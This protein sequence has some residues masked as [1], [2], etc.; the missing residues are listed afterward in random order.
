MKVS[1][2][3]WSYENY[4]FTKRVDPSFCNAVQPHHLPHPSAGNLLSNTTSRRPN[5]LH[6]TSTGWQRGFRWYSLVRRSAPSFSLS[7]SLRVGMKM[8]LL[9]HKILSVMKLGGGTVTQMGIP[10]RKFIESRSVRKNIFF[11]FQIHL[12]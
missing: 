9:G 11:C 10:T 5:A 1:F 8:K 12:W 4:L 2:N 7:F 3:I 6:T